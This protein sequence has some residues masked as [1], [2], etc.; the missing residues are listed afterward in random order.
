MD[1]QEGNTGYR[2]RKTCLS[3][4]GNTMSHLVFWLPIT[5]EAFYSQLQIRHDELKG[6]GPLGEFMSSLKNLHSNRENRHV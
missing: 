2:Q 5:P 6:V 1:D 3:R 4:G